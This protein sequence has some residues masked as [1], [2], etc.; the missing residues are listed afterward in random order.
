MSFKTT[1]IFFKRLL[2]LAAKKEWNNRVIN[3]PHSFSNNM[4]NKES[5]KF[6]RPGSNIA[7][8]IHYTKGLVLCKVAA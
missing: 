5:L 7:C 2:L 4:F 3:I 8:T 6:K 1:N